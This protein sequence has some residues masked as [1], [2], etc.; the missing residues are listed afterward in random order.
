MGRLNEYNPQTVSHPGETLSEKLSELGM[1]QKEFA[2]RTSKPEQTIVKVLSGESSITSDM[3][4]SFETVLKIPAN[5]WLRRQRAYDESAARE[6][7]KE[8]VS[9]AKE[10]ASSFPYAK[11][12]TLGW[13][14][15]TRKIEEK[16]E[17]LFQ[18]FAVSNHNAWLE[19][20][21]EQKL[22]LSFRISLAHTNKPYAIASWLR[23]GQIQASQLEVCAFD[24][25]LFKSN[26][27]KIKSIMASHPDNFFSE[28]KRLCEEAGVIVVHTPCLPGAPIHGSTRWINESPLIQLSARYRQNDIFWFTFF[29][30]AAHILKHGKKYVSLENVQ[31]DSQDEEKEKE[32][33]DFAVEW[34]FSEKEEK[35]VLD[36]TPLTEDDVHQFAKEFN[37]HPGIIIGRF[38]HKKLIH[39]SVGR[40]FIMPI[41]LTNS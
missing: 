34:T 27:K 6:R 40:K 22:K 31:Y 32:A 15:P 7:R 37:T 12:A 9:Q 1:S 19:Y 16:V 23:Q 28:L 26:L 8:A 11:M 24:K 2:L 4:V 18:F 25:N 36:S 10:W 35:K 38:H 29:H 30:E 13:V 3:A 39:Y 33:D 41:D 21:Y 14:N 17:E 5:F 20:Y